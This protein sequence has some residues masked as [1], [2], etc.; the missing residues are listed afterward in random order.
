MPFLTRFATKPNNM[1]MARSDSNRST[2][3]S[4]VRYMLKNLILTPM[5][6][7]SVIHITV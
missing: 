1:K 7:P 2:I 3:L 6:K 5:T 4:K